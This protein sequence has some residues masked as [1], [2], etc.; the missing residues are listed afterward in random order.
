MAKVGVKGLNMAHLHAK[1]SLCRARYWGISSGSLITCLTQYRLVK[2]G[3]QRIL[4]CAWQ[5]ADNTRK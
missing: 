3:R 4:C 2:D 1:S 5:L